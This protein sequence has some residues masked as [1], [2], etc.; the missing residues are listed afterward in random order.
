MISAHKR[1]AILL[2]NQGGMGIREITR[3]LKVGR[4]TVRSIIRLKDAIPKSDRKDKISI[5]PE[6]LKRLYAECDGVILRVHKKLAEDEGAHIKYSTLTHNVRELGLRNNQTNPTHS[7]D[8]AQRWLTELILSVRS[9][10][11]L[12]AELEDT[13]H[14]SD[15]IWSKNSSILRYQHSTT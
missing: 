1:E 13:S 8:A 4:N 12:E 14:I 10:E 2:L 9:L 7:L 15:L 5:E 11:I 6:L 3:H